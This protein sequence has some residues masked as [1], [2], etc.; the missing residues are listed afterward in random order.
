MADAITGE[1]VLNM[2]PAAP[3]AEKVFRAADP[4]MS[5]VATPADFAAQFPTP[6]DPLEVLDLC[7]DLGV[8]SAIPE[9]RTGLKSYTWREMTSLAFTSGSQYI[10]FADGV[11]PE[12]YQHDGSNETVDLKNLGAKKSLTISDIMHSAA[13]IGAGGISALLGGYAA[14][15]GMPGGQDAATFVKDQIADLK[16]KEVRLGMTLVLNGWDNMLVNG[17]TAVSALEFNGI[18]AQVTAAN[19][20]HVTSGTT[21]G[22]FSA[23]AFDQFLAASC[24]KPTDIF[25]HPAAIQGLLS[26]YFQT[27]YQGQQVVSY[28]DGNRLVP[29]INFAGYVNTA[30]GRLAVHADTRFPRTT[31]GTGG[32]SSIIYA[33]R[34]AHNGEPLVY[35]ITQIPLSLRDLV[36]GCSAIDFE[37]WT[38]TALIIKSMCAQGAYPAIFDGPITT[39]CTIIG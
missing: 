26:A 30:V 4:V 21:S 15:E 22:S 2:D 18:V 14:G 38:K 9:E 8:W 25:G 16:A 13:S 34:M 36:L 19:G 1:K 10:A 35:K 11:C 7:E 6:L 20:A 23:D 28:P 31:N 5:N 39:T 32:F 33:L 24:A 3:P 17:S 29:G 12:E 27:Q 37:I